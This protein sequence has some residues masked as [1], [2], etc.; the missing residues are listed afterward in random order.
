MD[1]A[2]A[3]CTLYDRMEMICDI[4]EKEKRN[5]I[6]SPGKTCANRN[7]IEGARSGCSGDDMAYLRCL[8]NAE[9][10]TVLYSFIPMALPEYESVGYEPDKGMT[11]YYRRKVACQRLCPESLPFS[12]RSNIDLTNV[13]DAIRLFNKFSPPQNQTL[14]IFCT[15][16]CFQNGGGSYWD[17][18]DPYI[19]SVW[20]NFPDN[21]PD[22]TE[23]SCVALNTTTGLPFLGSCYDLY[24]VAVCEQRCVGLLFYFIIELEK[25]F[26]EHFIDNKFSV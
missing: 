1:E 10:G 6:R 16:F 21:T 18:G 25:N 11:T 14:R 3:E 2:N 9:K 22:I 23:W 15:G 8:A 20:P 5:F 7:P 24:D 4:S 17:G 26:Q 12:I 13:L 19:K